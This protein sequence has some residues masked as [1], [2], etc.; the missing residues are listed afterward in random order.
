MIICL[1][2]LSSFKNWLNLF[3]FCCYWSFSLDPTLKI[4]NNWFEKPSSLIIVIIIFLF[5]FGLFI[6]STV[7]IMPS[8]MRLFRFFLIRF[9]FWWHLEKWFRKCFVLQLLKDWTINFCYIRLFGKEIA[10]KL[11]FLER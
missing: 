3:S 5:M 11:E 2:E 9:A 8:V 10:E 4:F 6:I 7:I 1:T